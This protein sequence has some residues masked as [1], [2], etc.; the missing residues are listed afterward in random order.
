VMFLK[1]LVIDPERVPP[2]RTLFHPRYYRKV[3]VLR[4]E[5]AE[6]MNRENFSNV[7]ILPAAKH[8]V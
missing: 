1:K 2:E 8:T 5:L 3:P 7:E 6:A 4:R